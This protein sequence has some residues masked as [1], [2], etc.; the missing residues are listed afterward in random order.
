MADGTINLEAIL[1]AKLVELDEVEG[2]MEDIRDRMAEDKKLLDE[3]AETSAK[4]RA[5]ILTSYTAFGR[6][7]EDDL[8]KIVKQPGR[9]SLAK[10]DD[11]SLDE[12]P[13]K[14]VETKITPVDKKIKAALTLGL[15]VPGY[16]LKKGADY[17][18]IE[19]KRTAK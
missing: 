9:D 7:Y 15:K 8:A 4:L 2:W 18:A 16:I 13:V 3:H 19:F 5:E 14:Y 10:T 1:A 17:V 12:V 11:W 6:P